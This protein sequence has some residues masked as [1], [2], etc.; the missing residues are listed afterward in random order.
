MPIPRN[1]DRGATNAGAKAWLGVR[2]AVAGAQ[3]SLEIG[4][5]KLLDFFATQPRSHVA[6]WRWKLD[7]QITAS[8]TQ[9]ILYRTRLCRMELMELRC[10]L[11][12]RV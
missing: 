1:T 3:T 8:F 4:R 11:E 7:F 9:A 10:Q 2:N 5:G 12:A 6:W